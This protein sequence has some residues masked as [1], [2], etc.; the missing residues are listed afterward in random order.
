MYFKMV[1]IIFVCLIQHVL[2]Q[3]F[4][5][6]SYGGKQSVV[7]STGDYIYEYNEA[8]TKINAQTGLGER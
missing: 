5:S 8:I 4:F 7:S 6:R 2:S 3:R 1:A